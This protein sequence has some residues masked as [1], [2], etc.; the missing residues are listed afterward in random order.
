MLC[1]RYLKNC[2]CSF[3][4]LYILLFVYVYLLFLYICYCC[5]QRLHFSFQVVSTL[6]FV[7]KFI[8]DNPL[9]VCSDEISRTKKLLSTDDDCKLKQKMGEVHLKICQG[10]YY[11]EVKITVPDMYPEEQVR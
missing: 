3:I 8:D 4:L 5:F 11:L 1:S 6:K 7:K 9:C 2:H 10:L